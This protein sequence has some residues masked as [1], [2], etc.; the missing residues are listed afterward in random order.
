M[1]HHDE[2][3]RTPWWWWPIGLGAGA[4]LAAEIHLGYQ[5]LR[6]WVPYAVML[7]V[8][9]ALLWWLGRIRIRVDDGELFVDDAH[10]PLMHV[11]GIESLHAEAKRVALGPDLHVLAFVVH[12]PWVRGAIKVTLNDPTDPTPYWI[13]S[14][15]DP[16][17]L[18]EVIEG[19]IIAEST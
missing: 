14:S 9:G 16:D 6:S 2:R 3:L 5:G 4:L 12:R 19:R 10:V 15:R 18:A 1:H 13:I 17:R 11:G 7:P 8:A